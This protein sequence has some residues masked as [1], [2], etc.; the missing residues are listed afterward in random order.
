MTTLLIVVALV[1]LEAVEH[2]T[3]WFS[4]YVM[5]NRRD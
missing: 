3:R 4:D 1:L 5:P 2:R